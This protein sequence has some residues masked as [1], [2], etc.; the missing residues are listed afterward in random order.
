MRVVAFRHPQN[1]S[2]LPALGASARMRLYLLP[3]TASPSWLGPLGHSGSLGDYHLTR[4]LRS[5]PSDC[6][7]LVNSSLSDKHVLG[8]L[9]CRIRSICLSCGILPSPCRWWPSAS[10]RRYPLH[11]HCEGGVEVVPPERCFILGSVETPL[12]LVSARVD[13]S[14]SR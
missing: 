12:V 14:R 1:P 11:H 7:Q 2:L 9:V 8:V 6:L 5:R 3:T 10:L 13:A 4:I